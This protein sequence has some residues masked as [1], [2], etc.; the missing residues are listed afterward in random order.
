MALVKPES[1]FGIPG[2][3]GGPALRLMAIPQARLE[4]LALSASSHERMVNGGEFV[5]TV[6]FVRTN[7]LGW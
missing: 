2:T 4:P 1:R 7:R 3:R 5:E 6:G